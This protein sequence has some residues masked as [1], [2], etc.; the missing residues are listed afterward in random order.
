MVAA[1]EIMK[2][3]EQTEDCMSKKILISVRNLVENLPMKNL[4]EDIKESELITRYVHP[5]LSLLLDDITNNIMFRWTSTTNQEWKTSF[6]ISK[7]QPD[8]NIT[9]INGTFHDKSFGF[10][11][12]DG[13]YIMLEIGHIKIPM[14]VYE[15][16]TYIAHLDELLDILHVYY[17]HILNQHIPATPTNNRKRKTI[18]TPQFDRIVDK[19]KDKKRKS[20]SS[21]Y[22]H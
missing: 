22:D 13:L 14:S 17:N 2:L 18:T 15:I 3:M 4:D 8:S 20:I 6:S 7:R 10:G 1:M 21:H 12:S 9:E 5:L 11:E 16:P 19:T